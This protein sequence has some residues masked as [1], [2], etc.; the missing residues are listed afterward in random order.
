MNFRCPYCNASYLPPALKQPGGIGGGTYCPEC[1]GRVVLTN[2]LGGVS[3]VVSFLLCGALTYMYVNHSA[4]AVVLG[5]L[6]LGIPCWMVLVSIS[7]R[8]KPASLKKY[9]ELKKRNRFFSCVDHSEPPN[10]FKR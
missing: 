3:L 7:L 1:Q 10:L 9:K 2:G 4:I 8:F 6:I 5:S